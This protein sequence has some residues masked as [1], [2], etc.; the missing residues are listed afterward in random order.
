MKSCS[1]QLADKDDFHY[2]QPGDY[3][4]RVVI[5]CQIICVKKLFI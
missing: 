2:V 5:I 3:N 1:N 4:S